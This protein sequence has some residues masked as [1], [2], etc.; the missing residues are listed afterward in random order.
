MKQFFN[1]TFFVFI[2]GWMLGSIVMS[3][4]VRM[5]STNL[6]I[7]DKITV[8]E[9]VYRVSDIKVI[10]AKNIVLNVYKIGKNK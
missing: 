6:M 10:D 3:V 7:D 2:V 1:S 4:I 8:K 9:Q 5:D